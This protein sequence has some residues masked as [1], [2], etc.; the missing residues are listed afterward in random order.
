MITHGKTLY[1]LKKNEIDELYV[2]S[3]KKL[4]VRRVLP[5]LNEIELFI[6]FFSDYPDTILSLPRRC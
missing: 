2:S 1:A 5:M 4:A 6:K 3:Y